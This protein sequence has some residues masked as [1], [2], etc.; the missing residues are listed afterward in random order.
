[1]SDDRIRQTLK[2]LHAELASADRV[3]PELETLLKDVDADIHKLL[4]PEEDD[5]E[6]LRDR[7]EELAAAFAATHPRAEGFL[8][9]LVDTLG[10][11]GI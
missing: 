6:G 2:E 5:P 9:E 10:K 8:R 1:M 11:M 3:D 4:E 7:V